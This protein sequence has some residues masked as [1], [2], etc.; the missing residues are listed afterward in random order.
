MAKI[1]ILKVSG[2]LEELKSISAFVFL[3][4]FN[5]RVSEPE[6]LGSEFEI[7]IIPENYDWTKGEWEDFEEGLQVFIED[8]FGD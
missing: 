4:D 6:A 1:S 7:K 3:C 8:N 2:T 5:A